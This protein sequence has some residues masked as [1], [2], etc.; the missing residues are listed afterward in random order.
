MMGTKSLLSAVAGLAFAATAFTAPAQ[1]EEVTLNAVSGFAEGTI[2]SRHFEEFIDMVNETGK[3]QVQI[4]Y[5]GGGGKVIN[6]FELGDAVRSGVVQIGNL[7]GA[8]YTKLLPEIDAV[9]MSEYTITE[10]RENGAWAYMNDL[11]M[12]K[13]NVYHLAR[14]TE[15]IPFH[16]YLNKPID[17]PDLTGLKIRVTPIYRAFF[18][19][20]GAT[21]I[22][23]KPGDVYTALER[24]A[25][26]GY[27]W[28]SQGIFDL[29]WA[30]VTK[31]RVDPSFYRSS[32]EFIINLDA[33]NGLDEAQ[34]KVLQDAAF[35]I[36]KGC[37][38]EKVKSAA[39]LKRQEEAGIQVIS[40]T[41][42]DAEKY[43]ETAREA[44]WAEFIKTNP[45]NGEKIKGLL[46]K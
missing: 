1:A 31:Y 9:K 44:G 41:G 17:S 16:L 7:P 46:T 21:A 39:E 33:W 15:C 27:G 30:E 24:G 36:E 35:E 29:G 11:H 23:T 43:L 6:P 25:V 19:A 8:F 37:E 20:L 26:D 22:Q 14:Q 10:E 2:F 12:Q 3:G 28:P 42:A 13:M 4:S 34:K 32:V 40:F 5:K 18:T 45:E 38:A